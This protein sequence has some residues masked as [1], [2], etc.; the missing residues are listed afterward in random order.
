[1]EEILQNTSPPVSSP[2][3]S[4]RYSP[5]L[6]IARR[7]QVE[8]REDRTAAL[9]G[10]SFEKVSDVQKERISS[11]ASRKSSSSPLLEYVKRTQ[12]E[13]MERRTALRLNEINESSARSGVDGASLPMNFDENGEAISA[14][15]EDR[16]H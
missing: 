8:D 10:Q 15:V 6:A 13:V 16:V 2:L 14:T 4:V 12:T 1:M 5:P 11:S 3:G 9:M 7:A